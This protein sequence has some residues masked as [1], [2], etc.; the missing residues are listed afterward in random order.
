M[1][2]FLTAF[3]RTAAFEGGY[4]NDPD[5]NGGETYKG[6]SRR[7]NPNWA[8]WKIVDA[9]KKKKNF[10]KNLSSNAEL[11]EL[12]SQC[13]KNNY[14]DKVWGDKINHQKVANDMYDVAV[15]CG[16]ATSIKLSERQFGFKETGKMSQ[17]LLDKLNSVI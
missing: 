6:I 15:N 3:R 8:G 14:W 2:D 5:D 9:C 4:V 12:V 10:P 7:A 16:V 1:A 13:Y 17:T 11:Q